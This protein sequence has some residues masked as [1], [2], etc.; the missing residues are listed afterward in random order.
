[1]EDDTDLEFNV[2]TKTTGKIC[3]QFSD[4]KYVYRRKTVKN[5]GAA[6]FVCKHCVLFEC[7]RNMMIENRPMDMKLPSS[8]RKFFF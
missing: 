5:S 6:Y 4:S 3:H 8:R 1:M 7:Q 2:I